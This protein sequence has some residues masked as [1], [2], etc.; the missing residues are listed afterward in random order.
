MADKQKP[1]SAPGKSHKSVPTGEDAGKVRPE[2]G[3]D[4]PETGK[5]VDQNKDSNPNQLR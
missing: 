4:D 5:Q 1:G 3:T 2:G